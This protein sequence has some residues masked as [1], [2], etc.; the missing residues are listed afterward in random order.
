MR[1]NVPECVSLLAHAEA[2]FSTQ[3]HKVGFNLSNKSS[4]RIAIFGATGSIGRQTL[5]VLEK[6]GGFDVAVLSAGSRINELIEL[7]VRWK[8]GRVTLADKRYYSQLK[9]A[10]FGLRIN[11][12]AGK[13]AAAKAAAEVDYDI[14][15]NGLVG[16]AGLLPSYHSLSRGIDLA[17]ANKES[18]VLAGEILN[19][20]AEQTGAQILPVDSEHS[21]IWQCLRGEDIKDVER[22]II[23]ASGGPFREWSAEQIEVATP[24]EALKHP[25]WKMGAKI[26][27]D[28]ATLMNKGLE[29]IEAYHLFG[30]PSEKIEARIHPVSIVHSMVEFVDGSFKAQLGTPDMKHPIS[31]ALNYPERCPFKPKKDDPIDWP[32]LEFFE[33][34]K[35]KYPCFDLAYKVLKKGG[36]AA[37]VLNGADEAA[38]ERFLSG[39]IKFGEIFSVINKT[40]NRHVNCNADSIEDVI[41]ADSWAREFV[42]GLK[43]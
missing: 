39:G 29:V 16:V 35:A 25:T 21:A 15:L 41:M 13:D 22:L 32:A 26:T 30:I 42:K 5:E 27:I 2:S 6:I 34:D 24:E 17:L 23:T 33:V 10:L 43:M 37:A 19:R 14:A 31:Y 11:V 3:V 20:I 8:P 36:T 4:K 7:A 40:L 9:N 38:V 1:S 12:D 28:S 18:L